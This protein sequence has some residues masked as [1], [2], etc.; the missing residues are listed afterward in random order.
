MKKSEIIKMM[1][2]L[3]MRDRQASDDRA[4]EKARRGE[5]AE[6]RSAAL[7][8]VLIPLL[9]AFMER[10]APARREPLG[11]DLASAV[12]ALNR[13]FAPSQ[14]AALGKLLTAE[15]KMMMVDATRMAAEILGEIS[16]A[17]MADIVERMAQDGAATSDKD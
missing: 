5:L 8:S 11:L 16:P 6:Q 14:L 4:R 10:V 13:S 17:D 1:A 12:S 9:P 15:Q 3:L 2:D 7:F